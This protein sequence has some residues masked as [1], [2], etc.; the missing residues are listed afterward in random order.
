M[1]MLF[2]HIVFADS[3]VFWTRLRHQFTSAVDF[4]ISTFIVCVLFMFIVKEKCISKK[5]DYSVHSRVMRSVVFV[6]VCVTKKDVCSHTYWSNIPTKRIHT[7]SSS[8][9]YV[10]R[11]VC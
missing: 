8:T 11:D 1:C 4:I 6:C 9:F 5:R 3:V 2:A 7:A 10:T